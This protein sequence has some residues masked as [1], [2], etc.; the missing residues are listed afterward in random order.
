MFD[1]ILFKEKEAI[2][3]RE[4]NAMYEWLRFVPGRFNIVEECMEG[5]IHQFH[6]HARR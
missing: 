3:H 4:D 6:P 1:K 5:L 2:E